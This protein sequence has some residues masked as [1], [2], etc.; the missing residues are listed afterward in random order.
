LPPKPTCPSCKSGLLAVS[1]WS[2]DFLT[3]ILDKKL[4]GRLLDDDEV[5]V[6]AKT[7]RSA[8]LVLS[9]GRRAVIALCVYG[10]GPQTGSRILA[11]MHDNERDL[12]KYLLEAKLQFITTRPFWDKQ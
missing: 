3:H 9:Y 7:R 10:I 4:K 12:Y 6:L 1:T 8:D 11:K 2:T 5:K